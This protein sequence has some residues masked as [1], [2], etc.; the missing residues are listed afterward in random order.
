MVNKSVILRKISLVRRN[1]SRL[2]DKGDCSLEFLKSDLDTQDIVLHNL[3]L[4]VQGMH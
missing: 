2:E 1:I 4:A 3:Q